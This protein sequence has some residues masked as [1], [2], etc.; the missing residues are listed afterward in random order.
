MRR[1]LALLRARGGD[2]TSQPSFPLSPCLSVG[3]H[4]ANT[5]PPPNPPVI[6]TSNETK[7]DDPELRQDGR[8]MLQL[9]LELNLLRCTR[10]GPEQTPKLGNTTHAS[11]KQSDCRIR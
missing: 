11:R 7:A 10:S 2:D 6:R 1:A 4:R 8:A 5:T 3:A 9:L